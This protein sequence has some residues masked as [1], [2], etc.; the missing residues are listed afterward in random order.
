MEAG[1]I[2][3]VGAGV[4]FVG[5]AGAEGFEPPNNFFQMPMIF[6]LVLWVRCRQRLE[7]LI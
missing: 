6:P 3:G 4:V 7:H 2:G 5:G 1:C